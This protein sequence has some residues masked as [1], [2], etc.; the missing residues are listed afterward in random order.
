MIL[1]TG[2]TGT[3]GREVVSLLVARGERVRAVSRTPATAGLPAGVEVVAGDLA[4]PASLAPHLAGVDAVFLIW[5]FT[6]PAVARKHASEVTCLIAA[7]ATRI[8]YLSAPGAA[9]QPESFWAVVERAVEAS[10]AEWTFLRPVGFAANTLM[11][12]GQIRAGDVVRWPYGAAAR[13]LVHERD[14]AEVAVAALT[15]AGHSGARHLLSGPA[16]L[17]QEEQVRAIGRAVGRDLRWSEMP[18]GEA[19]QMLAAAFGDPDFA[20]IALRGWAAFVD[21]PEQVTDT[22]ERITGHPARPYAD[23]AADHADAFR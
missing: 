23:W 12:A 22:V 16:T 5:P 14:L 20:E 10:G 11:W 18:L 21:H 7:T 9:D 17:T 15:S 3:V 6:D 2:A 4:E 19:R 8:V 13:S 1:E